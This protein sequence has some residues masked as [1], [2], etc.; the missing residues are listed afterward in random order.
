EHVGSCFPCGTAGIR[1]GSGDPEGGEPARADGALFHTDRA[2][3]LHLGVPPAPGVQPKSTVA[4]GARTRAH[5][6]VYLRLPPL[7]RSYCA[8]R[9]HEGAN[10]CRSSTRRTSLA[11]SPQLS[12]D[13]G[14]RA[15]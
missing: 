6:R 2:V 13:A 14:P 4:T 8:F 1:L 12:V 7:R 9:I 15:V 10:A 5:A 11:P 3:P